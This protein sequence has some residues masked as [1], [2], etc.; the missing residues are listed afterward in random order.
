LKFSLKG[1]FMKARAMLDKLLIEQGLSG[2]DII[3]QIYREMLDMTISDRLKVDLIDR[4][5]EIDFRMAEGAN[6]RIQLEALI[7][8]FVL[9]GSNTN[10]S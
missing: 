5:G 2:E 4:I 6:E 10:E 7:A 1:D 8:H 3:G 9:C